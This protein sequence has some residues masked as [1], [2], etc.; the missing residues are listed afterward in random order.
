MYSLSYLFQGGRSRRREHALR[1]L[2]FQLSRVRR[3]KLAHLQLKRINLL[4]GQTG[5]YTL[6][7][8]LGPT[9]TREIADAVYHS[10]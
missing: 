1:D 2:R 9:S 6:P 10:Y 4:L 5:R 8:E 3:L 7:F